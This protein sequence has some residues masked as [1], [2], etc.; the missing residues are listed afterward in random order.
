MAVGHEAR[1]FAFA[2]AAMGE[3]IVF[4]WFGVFYHLGNAIF[5]RSELNP[6][7]FYLRAR[8]RTRVLRLI[9]SL[10]LLKDKKHLK[11]RILRMDSVMKVSTRTASCTPYWPR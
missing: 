3:R 2:F 8:A 10:N 9:E 1:V 7:T 4:Y 11:A 5:D 6:F